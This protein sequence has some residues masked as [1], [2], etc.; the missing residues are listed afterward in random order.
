M[1][2]PYRVAALGYLEAG[3]SPIPL[4]FKQ[5]FPVPDGTTGEAGVVDP[6][7]VRA[8]AG[9]KRANAGK[10]NYPPGNVALRLPRTILG[11][12]VDAYGEKKG[13]ETLSKAEMEWGV[14]PATWVTTSKSDGISGIRL[15]AIP[16]GL[17][18]PGELPQ[19]KGVELIRWDHRF[20][21]VAPSVHDKT[22]DT[23][24][25]KRETEVDGEL[26]MVDSPEEF[27]APEEIA[28]LPTEWVEGLTSGVKWRERAVSEDLT[29]DDIQEWLECRPDPRKVCTAMRATVTKYTR[30]IRQAS[31]D[32]GAH[33]EGRNA[34]W[35]VLGDAKAGHTG[36]VKALTELRNVFLAAVADRRPDTG[37]AR[38]EWARAVSRGIKKVD[39]DDNPD[40]DDDPCG[41][42]R[43][44]KP[45]RE[46]GRL[47]SADR[48]YRYDEIGNA[49]RLLRVMNGRARWVESYKCW[50]L[51]DEVRAVWRVDNDKQLDRWCVKAIN[52]I[53]EEAAYE[54]D[55]KNIALIKKWKK[56]SSTSAMMN[57]MQKI[58]RGRAGIII[59]AE[60]FDADPT[61]IGCANGVL[62]LKP[63]GASFR[64]GREGDFLTLNTG[65]DYRPDAKHALWDDY[66]KRFQPDEEVRSWLQMLVGYSLFG[67]N[68]EQLLVVGLGK[69]STGKTTITEGLLAA[70]G[71]YAGPLE[72]SLL[73]SNADDKPRPDILKA[74]PRR[75][76]IAEELSEF[77][78]L[79]VDQVKRITGAGTL[80]ARGMASN[81]Y[82]ER[83][84]AFTPWLMTNETP[85]IDG[86]DAA[87]KNRIL[88]VPF[89]VQ[90]PR[91]RANART[92]E[93]I[94]VEA[95]PAILAWA[96]E[97]W[98]AYVSDAV[99]LRVIPAGAL[100]AQLRF[101]S[102][103]SDFHRFLSE[104]C[105]VGEGYSV[106]PNALYGRYEEWC[107]DNG[108]EGK[109]KL[110]P[111]RFGKRMNAMGLE[112]KRERDDGKQVW[113]RQ[114]IALVSA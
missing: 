26:Q 18:W 47:G 40:V 38:K 101:S 36:V 43:T 96:V 72:A 6:A 28:A 110:T 13:E 87:L 103:M 3:W 60:A 75:I 16:E 39:A 107:S 33:D 8:W 5:K 90:M 35:A 1:T 111:I 45:K 114:G 85:T 94:L 74:M 109:E 98:N 78:H 64:R 41:S 19:G 53:D 99:D 20:A 113:R 21:I 97:G 112:L 82:V 50:Y 108:V 37:T 22:G 54:D 102:E 14:L 80:S 63:D 68:P 81:M 7:D 92:R 93:R 104:C 49:E 31:D 11:I 30:E 95:L 84:P 34:V 58:V 91:N 70:L 76:V 61:L 59:P 25:W 71:G 86:A 23:Y 65:V 10:L 32:G 67:R 106:A 48:V 24:G 46:D 62:E 83:T 29:A 42:I 77:Q 17:E 89:D 73:R 79:H 2:T 4:P 15:F 55:E 69:T 12:D 9:G 88:V 66:L 100:A 27:P 105:D 56:S 51:W 57:N 52:Q 44:L